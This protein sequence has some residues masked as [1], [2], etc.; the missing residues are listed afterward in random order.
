MVTDF[1]GKCVLIRS[2]S[3]GVFT[4]M[5]VNCEPSGIGRQRVTLLRSRRLWKWVARDGVALSGVATHGLQM[6]ESKV[7]S[8]IS[9][10]HQI[11]D[12]IEV[13]EMS[14]SAWEVVYGK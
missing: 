12:I 11:D 6:S 13:I 4:G 10:L 3:S 7:D 9:G 2:Y 14:P 8:E 5:L 1:S